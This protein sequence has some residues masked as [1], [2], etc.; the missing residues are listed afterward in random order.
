[1]PTALPAQNAMLRPRLD[2]G[3][4]VGCP[5]T[6]E[7]LRA[8]IEK[9]ER[10]RLAPMF[11]YTRVLLNHLQAVPFALELHGRQECEEFPA[12][13]DK[14]RESPLFETTNYSNGSSYRNHSAGFMDVATLQTNREFW[15]DIREY[16][17]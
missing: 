1:M 3:A 15:G 10:D 8:F 9:L 17:P 4:D 16:A 12:N 13:R 6:V 7:G 14:Y 5:T 11:S 2:Q